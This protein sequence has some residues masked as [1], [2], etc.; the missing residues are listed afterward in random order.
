MEGIHCFCNSL[1]PPPIS[2]RL[3]E[4]CFTRLYFTPQ[5]NFRNIKCFW[6]G[7]RR[8]R[9]P[10]FKAAPDFY[11]PSS[12]TSYH[13]QLQDVAVRN[14]GRTKGGKEKG[15]N[16][17]EKRRMRKRDKQWPSGIKVRSEK[18]TS[19]HSDSPSNQLT[20]GTKIMYLIVWYYCIE[21]SGRW[22]NMNGIT[23]TGKEREGYETW[24]CHSHEFLQ[25]S[26]SR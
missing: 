13:R 14:N 1:Y 25:G 5:N 3:E 12:V 10:L 26:Q 6:A 24:V 9:D 8:G 18:K 15:K 21:T 2:A 7:P 19:G 17:F 23:E 11:A 16:D 22:R 4:P 20:K